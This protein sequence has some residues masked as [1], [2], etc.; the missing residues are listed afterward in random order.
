MK[1]KRKAGGH[2]EGDGTLRKMGEEG[3]QKAKRRNDL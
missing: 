2:T 3:K 1:V